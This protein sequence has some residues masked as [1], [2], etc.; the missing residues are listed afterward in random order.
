MKTVVLLLVL[1]ALASATAMADPAI[2]INKDAGICAMPGANGDGSLI[3]GGRGA[4]TIVLENDNKVM[5]KCHGDNLTNLSGSGQSFQGFLCVI[6]APGG[7]VIADDAHATV[8]ASGQ[9][10]LT[11]TFIKD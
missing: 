4:V 10:E 5:L 7:D 8:S 3:F 1:L 9:G 6:S 11:C 2:V